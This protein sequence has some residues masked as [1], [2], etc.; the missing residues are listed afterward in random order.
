MKKKNV[1]IDALNGDEEYTEIPVANKIHIASRPKKFL[2]SN[3]CINA[4]NILPGKPSNHFCNTPRLN[5]NNMIPVV[6]II[7][8]LMEI[9]FR[10]ILIFSKNFFIFYPFLKKMKK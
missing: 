7:C 1:L 6:T 9:P 5:P 8:F 2:M 10:G 4:G 3:C